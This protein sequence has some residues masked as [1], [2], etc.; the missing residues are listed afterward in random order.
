MYLKRI[1]N[2]GARRREKGGEVNLDDGRSADN[3]ASESSL[4]G[5][6]GVHRGEASGE[7]NRGSVSFTRRLGSI[8][9]GRLRRP[10]VP[11]KRFDLDADRVGAALDAP[12]IGCSGSFAALN[13]RNARLL[14]YFNPGRK[15]MLRN[16]DACE[17][18]RS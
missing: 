12:E 8:S 9:R 11:C 18:L 10:R 4:D 3:N 6:A 15:N 1:L 14:M 16:G 13:S 17:R 5:E 7:G 2:D